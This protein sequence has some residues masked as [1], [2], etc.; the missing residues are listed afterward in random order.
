MRENKLRRLWAEG[1]GT[2]NG[3]CSTPSSFTAEIMAHQGWDSVTID[4][5]HGLVDYQAAVGMLQAISTTETVP[6]VRVP[7]REPGI[8]MKMLDAGAYGVICPMVNTPEEAE[9]LVQAC[10]YP[11][12]G[13]RSFGP[14]RAVVYAGADYPK[15]AN[16]EILSIAM[17]ETK[18]ALDNVDAITATDGLSGIYIGPADLANSLGVTPGFDPT[19]EGVLRAIADILAAAKKNGKFA[20]IHCGYPAFGKRML[21]DGFDF[22]TLMNDTRLLTLKAQEFLSEMREGPSGPQ[23]S[24]Y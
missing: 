2:I 12:R 23:S 22:V 17:I 19:D 9:E 3:W 6:L 15:H 10:S 8:L 5:Q 7:W 24:A 16:A 1:K 21:A 4:C 11:P 20:G 18:K 14:I 13:Q